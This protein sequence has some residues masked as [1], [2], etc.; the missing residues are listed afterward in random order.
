MPWLQYQDI[1][2]RAGWVTCPAWTRADQIMA[3]Q[4]SC[5]EESRWD[6]QHDVTHNTNDSILRCCWSRVAFLILTTYWTPQSC[7]D[8]ALTGRRSPL[9][10]CPDQCGE[11]GLIL[12]TTESSCLVSETNNDNIASPSSHWPMLQGEMIE[13]TVRI[14]WSTGMVTAGVK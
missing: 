9:P 14:S 4:H 7:S 6:W 3:V 2:R 1:M 12:W 5:L 10:G 8:P 11:W 13:I